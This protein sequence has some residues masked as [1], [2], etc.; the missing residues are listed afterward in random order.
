MF[1]SRSLT[2]LGWL[3]SPLGLGDLVVL[4]DFI[5][6]NDLVDLVDFIDP[7][8]LANIIDHFDLSR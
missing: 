8:N 2:S 4:L 6:I 7:V 1:S 5:E 3:H